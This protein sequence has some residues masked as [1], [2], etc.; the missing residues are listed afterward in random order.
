MK[1][2]K[3][4]VGFL[5]LSCFYLGILIWTDSR[6]HILNQLHLLIHAIPVLMCLSFCSFVLRYIRWHWLLSR[7]GYHVGWGYGFLGYLAG[8]A[9]TAT[10]GKV[11]ELIRI[12]YFT[13]AGVPSA[14]SFGA[15]V[16]ERALDLIVV[17]ILS[18]LVIS[19]PELLILALSFVTIFVGLLAVLSLNPILVTKLSGVFSNLALHKLA[20]FILIIRNGLA[21]C[22]TW[23]TPIDLMVS[24]T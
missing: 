9:F 13:R 22:R 15:F 1:L 23:F 24:L 19:R 11:G 12:R 18:A 8:F 17:L 14:I 21:S 10:P 3:A 7:S 6:S 16:Y 5:F 2:G 4:L 20:K